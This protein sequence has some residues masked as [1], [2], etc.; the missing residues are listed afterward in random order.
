MAS[1][2]GAGVIGAGVTGEFVSSGLV[3]RSVGLSVFS[4]GGSMQLVKAKHFWSMGQSLLL[5]EGHLTEQ[6]V[7]A[8]SQFAPQK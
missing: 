4:A 1:F 6:P 8:C 5:E 3:G 2:I 7:F